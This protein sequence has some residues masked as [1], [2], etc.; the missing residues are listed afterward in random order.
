MRLTYDPRYNV[1]YIRLREDPA[2]VETLRISDELNIDLSPDGKVCGIE[3]LNASE[4]LL[5]QDH[6]KLVVT[7]TQT[8]AAWERL[9]ASA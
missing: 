9:V 5:Q 1:A 7:N 6:G 2:E 8:G 4:Q 3:L